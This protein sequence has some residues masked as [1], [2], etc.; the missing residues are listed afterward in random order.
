MVGRRDLYLVLAACIADLLSPYVS[1][2]GLLPRPLIWRLSLSLLT[3]S[4]YIYMYVY[5][6]RVCIYI[7][8]Y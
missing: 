3:I 8:L 1:K 5:N 6:M 2:E 4:I 7:Y